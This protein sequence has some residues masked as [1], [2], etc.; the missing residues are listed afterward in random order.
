MMKPSL[1]LLAA[2]LASSAAQAATIQY[3]FTG[4]VTD[5]ADSLLPYFSERESVALTVTVDDVGSSPGIP[6]FSAYA[7]SDLIL[8]IGGD[9]TLSGAF[10][11]VYVGNDVVS[12]LDS[13]LISFPEGEVTGPRVAGERP[14]YADVQLDLALEA[15]ASAG[16]P[17]SI[18]LQL[19]QL[20][21]SNVLFGDDSN[22]LSFK[23]DSMEVVP[24]PAT[25]TL[26]L[27]GLLGVTGW[28]RIR[29]SRTE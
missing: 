23:I 5:V 2:F 25:G 3:H 11:T 27:A 14:S 19:V 13:F 18:P 7:A 22:R 10:G 12:E 8:T 24:E 21:R 17:I 15:F 4:T 29:A 9:Y 6:E 28:R 1:W 20:D 26:V 16:L